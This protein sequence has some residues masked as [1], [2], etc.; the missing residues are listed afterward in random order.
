MGIIGGLISGAAK[1]TG[2]AVGA[3]VKGVAKKTAEV[4]AEKAV[5]KAV[6][7]TACAACNAAEKINHK[8]YENKKEKLERL[9]EGNI[10]LLIKQ[11]NFNNARDK[12]EIYDKNDE[13]KYLVK[14]SFKITKLIKNA[15]SVYDRNGNKVGVIK[16]KK[17]LLKGLSKEY[18]FYID[19]NKIA[20]LEY[21]YSFSNRTSKFL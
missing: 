17:S 9:N 3:V 6:E 19:Q 21:E 16:E 10:Q 13:I 11:E 15:L 20:E 5:E 1:L 7:T 2:K 14:G 4:V 18:D 12:L 8:C